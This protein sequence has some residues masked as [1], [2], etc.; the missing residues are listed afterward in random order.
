MT[1]INLASD[2]GDLLKTRFEGD[3]L[4]VQIERFLA[5][6]QEIR[7]DFS[8]VAGISH[9]FADECFGTLFSEHGPDLFRTRLHL[10]GLNDEIKLA[11]R[12]VFSDR[13]KV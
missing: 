6:E 13:Q 10:S 4:R 5:I 8:G 2:F 11:L 7:V 9:S 3:L 1:T 12:W